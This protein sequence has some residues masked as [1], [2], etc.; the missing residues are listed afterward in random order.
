MIAK[1]PAN[2]C[3]IVATPFARIGICIDDDAIVRVDYLLSDG[4]TLWPKNALA[5]EAQG[6]IKAYLRDSTFRFDLPL[7]VLGSDFQRRVWHEI[8]RI[9]SG[10]TR[11]YGELAHA[12][13]SAARPVGGAC[14]SNPTPLIVP[15]HR[16]LAASG[17]IGGFMHSV[18]DGPLSIKRWLLRHERAAVTS[19]RQLSL[20]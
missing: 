12:I 4:A 10:Q 15:C 11:T 13:A 18:G 8:A 19:C 7:R 16:V 3:A 1:S 17:R 20:A 6:Q 2:Y 9:P 5:L 14:G